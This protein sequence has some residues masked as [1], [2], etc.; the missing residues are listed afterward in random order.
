MD[1]GSEGSLKGFNYVVYK[2]EPAKICFGSTQERNTCPIGKNLSGFQMLFTMEPNRLS[3]FSYETER[4]KTI[5]QR[6]NIPATILTLET[7]EKIKFRTGARSPRFRDSTI[8]TPSPTRYEVGLKWEQPKQA[9]H[10]FN[11]GSQSDR[12]CYTVTPVPGPGAYNFERW[13]CRKTLVQYNFGKPTKEDIIEMICIP[14]PRSECSKCK[15]LCV[16]DYWHQDYTIFLCMSCWWEERKTSEIYKK[17]EL[18]KFKK[19]R[20]CSFMHSHEGT[21]A[22]INLLSASKLRKKMNLER[23]LNNFMKC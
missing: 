14:R 17:K 22:T 15:N 12:A 7:G 3:P 4:Y 18:A 20:N 8:R 6:D 13:K 11:V 10:P 21:T 19:I 2:A 16:G 9:K 23:Y 1:H 5:S